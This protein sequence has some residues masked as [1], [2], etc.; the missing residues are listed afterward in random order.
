MT[1]STETKPRTEPL[2]R[3]RVG[4]AAGTLACLDLLVVA[5]LMLLEKVEVQ[6]QQELG[7]V[8]FGTPLNWVTQDQA[9]NPT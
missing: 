6:T 7:Q 5:L 4:V 1:E 2:R 8:A 3:P 9:L